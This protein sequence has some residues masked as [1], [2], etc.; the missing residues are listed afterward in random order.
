MYAFWCH[1]K[2]LK[3]LLGLKRKRF[4]FLLA[5]AKMNK[6]SRNFVSRKFWLSRKFSRKVFVFATVFVKS[7]RLR[8]KGKFFCDTTSYYENFISQRQFSACLWLLSHLFWN[9]I[10]IR[11]SSWVPLQWNGCLNYFET[12]PGFVCPNYPIILHSFSHLILNLTRIGW[13]T[14]FLQL[15]NFVC[16]SKFGCFTAFS[17]PASFFAQIFV[18]AKVFAKI[19]AKLFANLSLFS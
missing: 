17:L 5:K 4:F 12:G 11:P 15:L 19:F 8:V 1:S 18:F 6:F 2:D 9:T 3:F 10:W 14:A 13:S 16:L 7:F